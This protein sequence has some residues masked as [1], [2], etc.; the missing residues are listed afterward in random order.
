MA[1]PATLCGAAAA[2]TA[3]TLLLGNAW[4]GNR[5]ETPRS[6]LDRR[7]CAAAQQGPQALRHFIWRMRVVES[8]DFDDYVDD[9]TRRAWATRALEDERRQ[10]PASAPTAVADRR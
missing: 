3:A 9:T 4:A 7:A 8:L 1:V 5:C 2:L 10:A 6:P